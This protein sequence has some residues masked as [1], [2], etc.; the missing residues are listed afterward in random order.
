L[1]F[2]GRKP[3]TAF[4]QDLAK[5]ALAAAKPIDDIRGSAE[6]KRLLLGQ[7]MLA[8]GRALAPAEAA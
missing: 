7:L 2:H 5:A 4:F 6:Y 3:D 1:K 8:H